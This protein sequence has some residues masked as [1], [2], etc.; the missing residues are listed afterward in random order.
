MIGHIVSSTTCH[1]V[2]MLL[3]SLKSVSVIDQLSDWSCIFLWFQIS[4]FSGS[5]STQNPGGAE[6]TGVISQLCLPC[7]RHATPSSLCD[8]VQSYLQLTCCTVL[9]VSHVFP[10][11]SFFSHHVIVSQTLRM[12]YQKLHSDTKFKECNWHYSWCEA[13]LKI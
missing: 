13:V 10:L 8:D 3:L 9:L 2:A 12:H 11:P 4:H 6:N 1:H 7:Y 5:S